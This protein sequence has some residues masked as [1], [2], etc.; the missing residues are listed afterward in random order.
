MLPQNS[1]VTPKKKRMKKKRK[2]KRQIRKNGKFMKT[3]L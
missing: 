3:K 1:V 2:K